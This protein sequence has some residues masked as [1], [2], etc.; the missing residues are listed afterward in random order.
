MATTSHHRQIN[1]GTPTLHL[2]GQDI[3]ILVAHR[4][5]GLLMQNFRQG[6][7]LVTQLCRLLKLQLVRMRHHAR[8]DRLHHFVGLTAQKSHGAI[9][10]TL[11]GLQRNMRYT[12]GRT[13]LDLVEQARTCAVVI[14]RVFAGT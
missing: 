13:P 3:H 14:H 11:I 4:I 2:D 7:H 6:A 5:H 1:A 12:R 10:I 9:D 8:L